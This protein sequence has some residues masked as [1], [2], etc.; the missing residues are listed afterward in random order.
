MMSNRPI[1]RMNR[2]EATR[3]IALG[4]ASISFSES[5]L[6]NPRHR[7]QIGACDWSIGGHSKIEALDTAKAIGLDGLQISLGNVENNMHL[8]RADV[9]DAYREASNRTGIKLGSL[10]I[11]EM[12]SVPYKSDPRTEA[13]VSDSI[14]VAKDLGIQVVLL[15]FFGKGDL[16]NDAAGT[17]EVI[18]RLKKVA[19][20]AEA[21]DVYLAIESWLSAE[22]HMEIIEAV[23]SSHVK[24]YY[25]VANSTQM[26]YDI[27]REIDLLKDLICEVHMKENGALLGKGVIDFVKVRRALDA[28]HY[29]GWIHIEG[30]IPKGAEMMASYKANQQFLRQIF[31]G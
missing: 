23:G 14:D 13:W 8:R 24:V 30:A 27:Y 31:Q 10:A 1:Q 6:D 17:R 11:G 20:K 25:D 16:K 5:L 3:R 29:Q 4:L 21:A 26:G 9:R 12:N 7:Y 28:I 15:A 19:S 2:R 18:R 22:E